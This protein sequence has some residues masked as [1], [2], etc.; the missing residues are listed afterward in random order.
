MILILILILIL[1]AIF[2][3]GFCYAVCYGF[4]IGLLR[5]LPT[6]GHA[7]LASGGSGGVDFLGFLVFVT[8][9]GLVPQPIIEAEVIPVIE[10]NP[11]YFS[12]IRFIAA[13]NA[14]Q[15]FVVIGQA[16]AA[17]VIPV[18]PERAE[19]AETDGVGVAGNG[20]K[21]IIAVKWE[22]GGGFHNRLL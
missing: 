18:M 8:A 22:V 1:N 11:L 9:S 12:P 10:H 6:L 17:G 13:T 15:I 5:L 3:Y 19:I 20:F 4:V 14:A 16:R 21:E 2:G 7:A